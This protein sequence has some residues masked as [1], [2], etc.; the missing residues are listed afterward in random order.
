MRK[1]L[2]FSAIAIVALVIIASYH[3]RFLQARGTVVHRHRRHTRSQTGGGGRTDD[4]G[5]PH[6][7]AKNDE[8]L[9][10][11]QG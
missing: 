9:F 3:S 8:D 10:F 5:I 2:K 1:W 11:A 6:I 7:M 4:H